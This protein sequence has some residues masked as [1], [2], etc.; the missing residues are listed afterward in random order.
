MNV[1]FLVALDQIDA[2]QHIGDV[3]DASLLDRQ[4]LHSAV[5]VQ[6][7]LRLLLQEGDELVSQLYQAVLL[8]ST[9]VSHG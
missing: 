6:A 5:K 1:V 3:V 4:L 2:F 8:S 9:H 7:H